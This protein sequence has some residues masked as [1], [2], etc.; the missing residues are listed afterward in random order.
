M[1]NRCARLIATLT[2]SLLVPMGQ[3][4]AGDSQYMLG[5]MDNLTY[6]G[7]SDEP[8]VD[9]AW[10]QYV[11]G[12]CGGSVVAGFDELSANHYVPFTFLFTVEDK[13]LVTAASLTVGLRAMDTDA[14]VQGDIVHL[15]SHDFW[16]FDDLGF[17]P[18]PQTGSNPRTLV[19][20]NVLGE[21]VLPWLQDG[22]LNVLVADDVA[23]D[24]AV[25]DI[26]TEL[27][28]PGTLGLLALGGLALIRRKRA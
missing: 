19:L 8:Y 24:Y 9:A 23:V 17:M 27:P 7:P 2:V 28:E 26:R 22:Q 11:E 21:N 5:D 13:Y 1:R 12:L 10:L 16:R 25:L 6:D 4:V 3:A 18:V 14:W 20:S 15:D